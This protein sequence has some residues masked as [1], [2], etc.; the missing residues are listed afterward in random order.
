MTR[1]RQ[2][3]KAV[4]T[5]HL[6][7]KTLE[8]MEMRP[9]PLSEA[10][11]AQKEFSGLSARDQ[12]FIRTLVLHV[13]RQY[14]RL[15]HSI[16]PFVKRWPGG[17]SGRRLRWL[18]RL[19]LAELCFLATPSYA[20]VK[21]YTSLTRS[22]R[23]GG[24]SGLVNAVLRK[25]S[26]D[27][28]SALPAS[29]LLH[30]PEW[31]QKDWGAALGHERAEK[32]AK[33]LAQPPNLDLS[34]KSASAREQMEAVLDIPSISFAPHHLRLSAGQRASV[35]D[36]PFYNQGHWWVQDIAASLP[37][38]LFTAPLSGQKIL[39]LCAAPG[40]KTLQLSAAGA[41]VQAID[42]NPARLSRLHENLARCQLSAEPILAD[43]LAFSPDRLNGKLANGVL[44]D[45]PCSATGT[46]RRHPEIGLRLWRDGTS[47][48]KKTCDLQRHLLSAAARLVRPGG[49]LIYSVCS[50]DH[51]EGEEQDRWVR[52]NLSDLLKP[53]P[54]TPEQLPPLFQN[55]LSTEGT[56]KIWPDCTP[57][58]TPEDLAGCDGFFIARYRRL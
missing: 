12:A 31:L 51:D 37:A 35:Q 33:Y 4:T 22:C 30:W 13:L 39:D 32:L 52:Q 50:L 1:Q 41:K 47:H 10:L 24:F 55:S 3:A 25:L 56:I 8:N 36:L 57:V 53:D 11:V 16:D 43:V 14:G 29:F 42:N 6:A 34:F 45:A 27:T 7:V 49:Q 58:D 26:H 20:V 23:L 21:E 15:D 40:G 17:E 9:R 46:L 19:G 5:R 28:D 38:T 18:L 48:A 54:I 44:L 2:P